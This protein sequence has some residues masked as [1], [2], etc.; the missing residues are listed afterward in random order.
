MSKYNCRR[1][2]DIFGLFSVYKI[3]ADDRGFSTLSCYILE[4]TL[5]MIVV[6]CVVSVKVSNIFI[7]SV[8]NVKRIT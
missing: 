8:L 4:C 6:K 7:I 1:I 5:Y 3:F 2:L